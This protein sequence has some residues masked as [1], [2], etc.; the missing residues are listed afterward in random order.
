LLR[1]VISPRAEDDLVEIAAYTL[2]TWGEKRMSRYVD[3][4]QARFVSL[5]RF[6]QTGRSRDEIARGYRSIVQGSH[7]VF[8]K[9]T[10]RELVVVRILH[11]RMSPERH[12]R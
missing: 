6:P 10:A 5:A 8:Y 3:D 12:L 2:T 4:L 1:I 11:V 7:T 9:T